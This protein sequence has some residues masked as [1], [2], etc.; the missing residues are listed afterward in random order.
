[1]S[2]T[3]FLLIWH[4]WLLLWKSIARMLII[5]TASVVLEGIATVRGCILRHSLNPEPAACA[6]GIILNGMRQQPLGWV[7]QRLMTGIE[8]EEF[9]WVS[10]RV[11]LSYWLQVKI[12]IFF[13]DFRPY[14]SE[15]LLSCFMPPMSLDRSVRSILRFS[16]VITLTQKEQC[17]V[18]ITVQQEFILNSLQ[19][20]TSREGAL[21][22]VCEGMFP[23]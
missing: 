3:Y 16:T 6:A 10:P 19:L 4:T 18:F 9:A 17:Q 14:T 23:F 1:M 12:S 11:F 7:A 5:S 22:N 20:N 15:I 2:W 21:S 13:C 8:D